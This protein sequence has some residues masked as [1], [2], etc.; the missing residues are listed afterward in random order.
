MAS[1]IPASIEAS[2]L[3]YGAVVSPT[4]PCLAKY[5]PHALIFVNNGKI[6]WVE[7]MV[8]DEEELS[9][10]LESKGAK[11]TKLVRLQHGQFLMPGFID[12]HTVGLQAPLYSILVSLFP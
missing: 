1:E 4:T 9:K 6:G 10:V 12:T 5:L 7:E 2:C 11:D 3:Y 8:K